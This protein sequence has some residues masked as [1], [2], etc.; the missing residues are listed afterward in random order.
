MKRPARHRWGRATTARGLTYLQGRTGVWI[1]V[2][3]EC[4]L[5]RLIRVQRRRYDAFGD[6]DTRGA[7]TVATA[8]ASQ[9]G[10]RPA[11]VVGPCPRRTAP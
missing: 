11:R 6:L 2:C 4:L 3:I 7:W 8:P 9:S 5:R 1:Q 10:Y